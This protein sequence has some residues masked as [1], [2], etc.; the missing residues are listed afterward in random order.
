MQQPDDET[1]KAIAAQ[2]RCPSGEQGI[3]TGLRMQQ[4]NDN[5]IRSAIAA[6]DLQ[7]DERILEIGPGRAHHLS[8]ILDKLPT[9]SYSGIDISETMIKE[10]CELNKQ[11]CES[12]QATFDLTDGETIPFEEDTFAKGFTVNT[13]YFWSDP[14]TYLEE[15]KRVMRPGG[16][17][18]IALATKDFM[19]A[20]PFTQ[21]GFTLY[22]EAMVQELASEAGWIVKEVLTKKEEVQIGA[23]EFAE[24]E[25]LLVM[26]EK[27]E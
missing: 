19:Q 16:I 24:R 14:L 12:G 26:V 22:D 5:M 25:F 10:A 21:F 4:N 23:T 18:C 2:L 17:F 15:I 11:Y 3:Q 27:G 1:L 7:D 8:S 9:V 13:I 20:L 6:L